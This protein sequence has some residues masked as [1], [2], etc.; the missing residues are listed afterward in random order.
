[1][2][3]NMESLTF[4]L[5]KSSLTYHLLIQ[6]Y[7]MRFERRTAG[8]ATVDRKRS[9]R[10]LEEFA[11]RANH[12]LPTATQITMEITRC[13]HDRTRWPKVITSHK[14]PGKRSMGRPLQRWSETV[15]DHQDRNVKG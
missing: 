6:R 9:E 11:S 4:D 8:C 15:T 14:P 2:L 5:S 3:C 13:M 7:I 12:R 1:M 10:I